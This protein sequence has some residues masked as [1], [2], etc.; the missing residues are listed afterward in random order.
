MVLMNLLKKNLETLPG[1][2]FIKNID[3]DED[4]EKYDFLGILDDNK[5]NKLLEN[6]L[7][8]NIHKKTRK[9]KNIKTK[10]KKK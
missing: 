7:H 6:I 1:F 10:T 8:T 2:N 5:Y 9:Y 4:K 3:E